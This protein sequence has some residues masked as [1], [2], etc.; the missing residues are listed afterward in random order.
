M[1]GLTRMISANHIRPVLAGSML[2]ACFGVAKPEK[3]H[4]A[5]AEATRYLQQRTRASGEKLVSS[6]LKLQ[7]DGSISGNAVVADVKRVTET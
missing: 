1:D 5:V 7:A 6:D 3:T 4:D 2:V